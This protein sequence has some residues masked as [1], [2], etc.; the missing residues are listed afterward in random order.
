[1]E[2][3]AITVALKIILQ[4]QRNA[5]LWVKKCQSSGKLNHFKPVRI[6]IQMLE[7][8]SEIPMVSRNEVVQNT[9]DNKFTWSVSQNQM[10]KDRPVFPVTVVSKLNSWL[11]REQV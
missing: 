10:N 7:E 3:N 1:M 6:Q 5:L 11:I 4:V 8:Q 9:S 2:R